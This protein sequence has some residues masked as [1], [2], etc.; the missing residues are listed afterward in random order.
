MISRYENKNELKVE[1]YSKE[2][3]ILSKNIVVNN[4]I[5]FYE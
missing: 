4:L 5:D 3:E 2:V 1:E